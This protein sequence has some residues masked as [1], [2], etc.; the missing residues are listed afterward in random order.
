MVY[1]GF[2]D[3]RQDIPDPPPQ[4]HAQDHAE[5]HRLLTRDILGNPSL[6]GDISGL[7]T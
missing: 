1:T 7:S 5:E 6:F 3:A 4:D 2:C